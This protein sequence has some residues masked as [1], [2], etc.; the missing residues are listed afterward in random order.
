MGHKQTDGDRPG[1]KDSNVDERGVSS[2][3]FRG[4][5]SSFQTVFLDAA[6]EGGGLVCL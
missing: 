4:S 2:L 5:I 1:H 6:V 3:T